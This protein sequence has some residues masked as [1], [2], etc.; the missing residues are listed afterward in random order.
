MCDPARVVLHH[1]R[2]VSPSATAL[3]FITA[4]VCGIL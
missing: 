1:F 2:I 3:L 4:I